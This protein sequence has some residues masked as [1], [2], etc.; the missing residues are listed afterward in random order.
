VIASEVAA[1]EEA[2]RD[3]IRVA[4]L[5]RERVPSYPG[6]ARLHGCPVAFYAEHAPRIAVE[7]AAEAARWRATY[8]AAANGE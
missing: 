1:I 2:W 6:A 7:L 4:L 8:R 5:C 3:A